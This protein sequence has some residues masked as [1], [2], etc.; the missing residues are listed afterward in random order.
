[1]NK[2]TI[3]RALIYTALFGLIVLGTSGCGNRAPVNDTQPMAKPFIIIDKSHYWC[4]GCPD[5]LYRFKY[6]DGNGNN[7]YFEDLGHKYSIGDT[8]H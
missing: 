4:G 8:I 6:I 3:I 7:H 5:D 1:M 2:P